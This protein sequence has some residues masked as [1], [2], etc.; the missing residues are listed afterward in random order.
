[1]LEL[2]KDSD[3]A[4]KIINEMITAKPDDMALNA[5]QGYISAISR[6]V[7]D[8]KDRR[9][10][11][12]YKVKSMRHAQTVYFAHVKK[13]EYPAAGKW[14]KEAKQY[15]AEVDAKTSEIIAGVE[16]PQMF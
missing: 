9:R 15:E 16:Q 11:Y 10:N 2:I 4:L 13:K 7:L 1:M 6:L 8:E 5:L 14:L 12:A 3:I